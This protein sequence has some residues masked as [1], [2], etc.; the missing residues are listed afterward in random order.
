MPVKSWMLALGLVVAMPVT[1]SVQDDRAAL[2]RKL[3]NLGIFGEYQC[4][5]Q[6][7]TVVV[8][9][10]FYALDFADR[11]QFVS[12]VYAYCFPSPAANV[13]VTLRDSKTNKD[14]GRLS[15]ETGLQM[16]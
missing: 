1:A 5:S 11:Q 3:Q 12:V 15:R 7:G 9:P 8:K 2:L 6:G 14:V 16:K 13:G 4:R 10:A